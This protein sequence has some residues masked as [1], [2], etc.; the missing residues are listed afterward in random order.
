MVVELAVTYADPEMRVGGYVEFRRGTFEVQGKRFRINQA[1]LRFDGSPDLNPD[2]N[3][4]ATHEVPGGSA[5]VVTVTGTFADP[6]ISFTSEACPGE[7]EALAYLLWGRC[8]SD[9]PIAA[10]ESAQAQSSYAADIVGA[11]SGAVIGFTQVE[12]EYGGI[13][14][15][16]AFEQ[17]EGNQ[18]RLKAGILTDSL[19]PKF[20]R[21][22]VQRVYVQ[23]AITQGQATGQE[24]DFQNV[25]A[26]ATESTSLDFLIELYFPH[27]IVGSGRF[28]QS[29]SWGVDLIWEP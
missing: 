7:G 10:Q 17:G 25:D 24:G 2:V 8:L 23:G 16:L 27:N 12:R 29:S 18:S 5:V 14:P 13:T 3:L 1:S 28:S 21:R 19:I 9:D 22:L 15:R 11:L 20:M 4:V 6:E 26:E